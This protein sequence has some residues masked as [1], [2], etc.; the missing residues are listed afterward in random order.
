MQAMAVRTVPPEKRG[1]ASSTFLCSADIGSGFGG[2]IA[3]ALV[4]VLGYKPMFGIMAIFV[5][6]SLLT[7]TLWASKSPS[8]FKNYK[9]DHKDDSPT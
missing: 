4:T 6:L 3:G 7:Y 8:A 9:R 2:L 5:F 1:S